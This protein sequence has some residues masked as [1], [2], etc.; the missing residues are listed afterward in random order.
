MCGGSIEIIPCSR[1]GHVF[2]PVIPYGFPQG[3]RL[4]LH[5]NAMRVAEVWMDQYKAIYYASQVSHC[6]IYRGA[7]I[8]YQ[9]KGGVG[10][11]GGLRGIYFA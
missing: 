6:H 1:V 4:T 9:N 10:D 8:Y 11:G 7:A 2:R 5:H 3:P